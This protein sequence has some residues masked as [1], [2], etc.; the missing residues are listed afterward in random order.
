MKKYKINRAFPVN[1][2]ASKSGVKWEYGGK[3]TWEEA[4]ETK[5]CFEK[6]MDRNGRIRD[7]GHC[8]MIGLRITD[9]ETGEVIYEKTV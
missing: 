7:E 5:D 9:T 6:Y 4:Q 8:A 3:K 2:G 1:T